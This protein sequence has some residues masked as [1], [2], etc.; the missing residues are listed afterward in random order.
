MAYANSGRGGKPGR[1]A[2]RGALLM[3]PVVGMLLLGQTTP[4]CEERKLILPNAGYLV[5]N[6]ATASV[7]VFVTL[8]TKP[9][10]LMA[11]DTATGQWRIVEGSLSNE[12]NYAYQGPLPAWAWDC[13]DPNECVAV[14]QVRDRN[15]PI[16][17]PRRYGEVTVC[18]K[19]YEYDPSDGRVPCGERVVQGHAESVL[20]K[21][22]DS[23]YIPD[24]V[25][26]FSDIVLDSHARLI[27]S[28]VT[29]N[30]ALL[31]EGAGDPWNPSTTPA[32]PRKYSEYAV[33][34]SS[35]YIR[36]GIDPDALS[37]E[38]L[39]RVVDTGAC[40]VF[41]PWEWANRS[42]VA[43][44]DDAIGGFTN[45]L[46]LAELILEEMRESLDAAA[47]RTVLYDVQQ[48]MDVFTDLYPREEPEFH[49]IEVREKGPRVCLKSYWDVSGRLGTQPNA[50]Y[51]IDQAFA[52]FFVEILQIGDC[53]KQRDAMVQFCGS[54]SLA[55]NGEP[56]F[57]IDDDFT[58][59]EVQPYSARPACNNRFIPRLKVL[60]ATAINE[61]AAK[62]IS[63]NLNDANIGEIFDI[64]R[65]EMMPSGIRLVTANHREEASDLDFC[66]QDIADDDLENPFIVTPRP[67]ID[68]EPSVT[69]ITRDLLP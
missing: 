54:F 5:V 1:S 37:S 22:Y 21:R 66:W 43:A 2:R 57:T 28:S 31:R 13:A 44:V 61:L 18:T 65:I 27:A 46:G 12:I 63:D 50:P 47:G 15:G 67:S 41:I 29:P 62:S 14:V 25:A 59:V 4:S 42:K 33:G 6:D 39:H 20:V 17:S 49:Y 48:W 26:P 38:N 56:T 55:E 11:R 34:K 32:P 52:A 24:D 19:D 16:V 30:G 8:V 9:S 40:G 36:F 35:R 45:D 7:T 69:G 3:A 10:F 51:R 64:Q 60:L 23:T 58:R 68:I 53:T